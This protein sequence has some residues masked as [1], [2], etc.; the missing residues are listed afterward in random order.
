MSDYYI[1]LGSNLGNR[2]ELMGRAVQALARTAG[3]HVAR[4]SSLYETPPWGKTDQPPFLNAVVKV[5]TAWG[6][7][8]LLKQCLAIEQS[9]GRQRHEKW[10]SRTIDLDL[11]FSPD[12]TVSEPDLNLPHPY[13][14]ERAFVLVPLAE[15]APHLKIND[16]AIAVYLERLQSEAAH[17]TSVGPIIFPEVD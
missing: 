9:L 4:M 3:I 11:L 6:P 5:T 2:A 14:T 12:W 7:Q 13:L 17:I 1:G 16:V 8:R 15:I 10:G